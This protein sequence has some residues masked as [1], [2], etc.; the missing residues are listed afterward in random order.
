MSVDSINFENER[1]F[2]KHCLYII[3][4]RMYTFFGTPYASPLYLSFCHFLDVF[5][6][7]VSFPWQIIY[8]LWY[9]YVEEVL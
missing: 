7:I 4:Q 2:N 8:T 6:L 9:I 3:I 5:F 1:Y